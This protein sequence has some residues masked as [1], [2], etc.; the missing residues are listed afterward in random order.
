MQ[1]ENVAGSGWELSEFFQYL[2]VFQGH[3]KQCVSLKPLPLGTIQH[4]ALARTLYIHSSESEFV[5][6]L[7]SKHS[8]KN[9]SIWGSVQG[10]LD[11]YYLVPIPVG[12]KGCGVTLLILVRNTTVIS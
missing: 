5:E 10:E 7:G 3:R 1:G 6:G 11:H 9:D 8:L 12:V 2:F 4:N